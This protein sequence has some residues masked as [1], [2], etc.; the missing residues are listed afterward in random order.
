MVVKKFRKAKACSAA[1][2]TLI[3]RS[4]RSEPDQCRGPGPSRSEDQSWAQKACVATRVPPP[5]AGGA[6]VREVGKT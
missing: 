3:P 2:K 5:P 4:F 6:R 1:F